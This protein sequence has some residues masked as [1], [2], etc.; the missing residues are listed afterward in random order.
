MEMTPGFSGNGDGEGQNSAS[1]SVTP[2]ETENRR[3]RPQRSRRR[4][5]PPE[6]SRAKQR[7]SAI[8]IGAEIPAA[9]RI[10]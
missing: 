10:F 9:L 3:L 8:F 2:Y 5:A 1:P 4:T 6:N 7:P